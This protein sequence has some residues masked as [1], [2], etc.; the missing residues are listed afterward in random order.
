MPEYLV[1]KR[2]HTLLQYSIFHEGSLASF[3]RNGIRFSSWEV[4]HWRSRFWLAE[5]EMESGNFNE[6]CKSF[7]ETLTRTVSRV[8]FVGQ[9]Y[10]MNLGQPYLIRKTNAHIA[11]FRHSTDRGAVPL[12]FADEE[13]KALD[14]LLL[15][16]DVPE[17]FYLYWN[18]A[19]NTFGYSS[20][21][22]LMFAALESL[23]Q[24]VPS[25]KSDFYTRIESVFGADLKKELYGTKEDKGKSG[26]RQRLVHGEYLAEGDI[27]NYV[28]VIHCHIVKHFNSRMLCDSRINES[29]VAP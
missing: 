9:A 14:A 23:F 21:L 16:R 1:Q 13:L 19:M 11:Y 7:Q 25:E 27:K 6:A 26:L 17:E 28:E 12:V 3:I 20:K 4:E 15:N 8:A 10:H 24:K 22:L 5:A 29:V 18:D 2:S